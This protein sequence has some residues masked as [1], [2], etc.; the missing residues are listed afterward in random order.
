[1]T[2]HDVVIV[3]GGPAGL[4]AA[5]ALRQRGLSNV[6][7]LEREAAAGGVPRHTDHIGF[8]LRDLH[9][10]MTG[11]QY[12]AALRNRALRAGVEIRTATTAIDWLGPSALQIVD[13]HGLARLDGRA[14]VLATGVRERPRAA[15]LIPGDRCAG[16]FTTG[17]LQQVT[18]L[19]KQSPGHKAVIIGAE[20]VSF[21]AITTLHDSGC[22]VAAMITP[23]P[24]HQTYRP[25]M[26]ATSRRHRVPIIVNDDVVEIH[27]RERVEA[28]TLRS[29]RRIA[30]DT[31]VFTGDW[32]PDHEL[33]RRGGLVLDPAHRGTSVDQQLRTSRPGVFAAGNLVHPVEAAD[34]CALDGRHLAPA[35]HRWLTT[36]HWPDEPL[37]I[38]TE[39]PITWVSPN[40]AFRYPGEL[41]ER[42]TLRFDRPTHAERIQVCQGEDV[43]WTGPIRGRPSPNR[44]CSIP[45]I[46][47]TLADPHGEPLVLRVAN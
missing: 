39:P 11:P 17:S 36:G 34:R 14:V 20:H 8:G 44:S 2:V 1:M 4:S 29:G 7:V 27:G 26:W 16:I 13:N 18:A 3:G 19:H 35:L 32:I 38:T 15:R 9:R 28:V 43:L 5:I 22:E 24:T 45:A 30:C 31:V 42:L 41:P 46:A 23:L 33:A 25:L 12:A 6:V 21:S 40:R 10:L 47:L 37:H